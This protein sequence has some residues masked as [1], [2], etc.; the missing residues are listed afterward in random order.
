MDAPVPGG[1]SVR[2]SERATNG[3]PPMMRAKDPV[4]IV[5]FGASG[6]LAK[7][8][9]IPALYHLQARPATCRSASR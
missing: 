3:A 9:L 7:R 2:V 4:T 1:V 6:D 5:I 8:K